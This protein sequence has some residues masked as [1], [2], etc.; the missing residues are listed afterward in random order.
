MHE[1]VLYDAIFI[2]GRRRRYNFRPF[3]WERKAETTAWL[4]STGTRPVPRSPVRSFSPSAGVPFKKYPQNT[5]ISLLTFAQLLVA[6]RSI[7]IIACLLWRSWG[8][9]IV[10]N[11]TLT[12]SRMIQNDA[13]YRKKNSIVN[14]PLTQCNEIRKYDL[15]NCTLDIIIFVCEFVG[16]LLCSYYWKSLLII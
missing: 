7:R 4:I 2:N 1:I 12:E 11:L 6:L 15:A 3:P 13:G 10:D 16:L 14:Y 5:V 9:V 8:K